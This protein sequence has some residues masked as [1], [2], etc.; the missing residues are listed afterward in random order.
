MAERRLAGR[1]DKSRMDWSLGDGLKAPYQARSKGRLSDLPDSLRCPPPALPSD[2][3]HEIIKEWGNVRSLFSTP[4]SLGRARNYGAGLGR[5][6]AHRWP[7]GREH[8]CD[9]R[10]WSRGSLSNETSPPLSPKLL[11]DTLECR[12]GAPVRRRRR[13]GD[14]IEPLTVAEIRQLQI[15]TPLVMVIWD[16]VSVASPHEQRTGR[17][18]HAPVAVH[19]ERREPSD[20]GTA[21]SPTGWSIRAV[22]ARGAACAIGNVP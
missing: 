12:P 21:G 16:M 13:Q 14:P 15:Q 2:R 4:H 9:E 11:A 8:A 5:L 22:S 20:H 19:R 1:P 3:L 18:Q 7:R 6:A 17:E 10:I